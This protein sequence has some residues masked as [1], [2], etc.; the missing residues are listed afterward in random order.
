M[1]LNITYNFDT[2]DDGKQFRLQ[3]AALSQKNAV[4]PVS[5]TRAIDKSLE[6]QTAQKK[7][8]DWSFWDFVDFVNPLQHIPV[9]NSIYRE[10][11]GD[12]IK[13]PARILG[14]ALFGGVAGAAASVVNAV[15]EETSGKDMGGHMVA[16]M[17]GDDK[18]VSPA[19]TQTPTSEPV[20]LASAS[21]INEDPTMPAVKVLPVE[22]H[23]VVEVY[24]KNFVDYE[25]HLVLTGYQNAEGVNNWNSSRAL[26][27]YD[28]ASSLA[29]Q[30]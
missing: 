2:F 28:R 8:D 19:K 21:S 7:E 16:F 11:T 12:Q 25:G 17:S 24:G 5:P 1:N 20:V 15:M 18:E 30:F 14:G 6:S 13:A 9:V 10:I 3:Q 23:P 26:K 4:S 29:K 22:T 27:S